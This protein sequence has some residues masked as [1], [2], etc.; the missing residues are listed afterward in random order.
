MGAAKDNAESLKS[1]LAKA[2]FFGAILAEKL[3]PL[4]K[5][6]EDKDAEEEKA[7][8]NKLI[9]IDLDAEY[10]AVKREGLSFRFQLEAT[11][12]AASKKEVADRA[13]EEAETAEKA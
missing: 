1:E 8:N 9:L 5:A 12:D 7:K 3:K 2:K 6:A 10:H 13:A 11:E 4:K